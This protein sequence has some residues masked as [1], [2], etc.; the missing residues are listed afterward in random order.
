MGKH[1][2]RFSLSPR[3]DPPLE[4]NAIH[5]P[6]SPTDPTAPSP[7][8]EGTAFSNWHSV[9]WFQICSSCCQAAHGSYHGERIRSFKREALLPAEHNGSFS[10]NFYHQQQRVQ[11]VLL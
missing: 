7:G 6:S 8:A 2:V 10:Y 3:E 5:F 11:S 9:P 1:A 4:V